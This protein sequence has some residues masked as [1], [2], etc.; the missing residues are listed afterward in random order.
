MTAKQFLLR[1]S[2]YC[3]RRAASCADPFL[4]EGLRRLAERFERTADAAAPEKMPSDNG[5]EQNSH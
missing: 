4:A 3:R 1:E 5:R 2:T